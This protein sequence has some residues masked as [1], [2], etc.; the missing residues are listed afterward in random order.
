M[1]GRR[2]M[3][4]P[5]ERHFHP[6]A[7]SRRVPLDGVSQVFTIQK[8]RPQ[9]A[10]ESA[11]GTQSLLEHGANIGQLALRFERRILALR[12]HRVLL[13]YDLASL[14]G[15]E[16][17]TLKQAVKRNLDCFPPDFM[18]ELSAVEVDDLVSRNV[19]PR[20][21]KLGG[22]VTM[23]FTEQGVASL[24]RCKPICVQ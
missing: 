2:G 10:R 14:Y 24:F 21:G 3:A 22:A 5:M 8:H 6:I 23:A 20:R 7:E 13:D 16:A 1:V 4:L 15:V 9:A 12:G 19:I 11:H 18:L 17:R